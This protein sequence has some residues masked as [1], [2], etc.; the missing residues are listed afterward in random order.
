MFFR[1]ICFLMSTHHGGN[2]VL[3]RLCVSKDMFE[4]ICCSMLAM[5]VLLK[6]LIAHHGGNTVLRRLCVSK[7]MVEYIGCSM[8][9]WM[10]S[11]HFHFI[12]TVVSIFVVVIEYTSWGK[13]RFK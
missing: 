12:C 5:L 10:S 8:L 9:G 7:D 1:N 11:F 3:S 13:Y 2:T 4:Y 6:V